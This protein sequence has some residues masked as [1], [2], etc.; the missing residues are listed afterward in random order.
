MAALLAFIGIGGFAAGFICACV[1]LFNKPMVS[2]WA[3]FPLG[4]LDCVAVDNRGNIY[5]GLAFYGRI[6]VYSPEGKFLRGW[7]VNAGGGGLRM[8]IDKDNHLHVCPAKSNNLYVFNTNGLL[9]S[10]N[11]MMPKERDLYFEYNPYQ[12]AEDAE[13]NPYTILPKLLVVPRVVKIVPTGETLTVVS[14]PFYL[15]FIQGPFPAFIWIFAG[16]LLYERLDKHKSSWR[17]K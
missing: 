14:D 3:R 7:F 15:W 11:A 13:G 1:T 5:C 2:T 6:Q 16:G 17:K 8:K 12:A 9:L 4:V 10:S